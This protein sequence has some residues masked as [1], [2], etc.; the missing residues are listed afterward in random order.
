MRIDWESRTIAL[1]VGDLVHGGEFRRGGLE[2]GD[3]FRRM[4]LGQE[5]H[6]RR[7]EE[8]A[9]AD[10]NYR[11]E[12][13]VTHTAEIKDWKLIVSGRIDGLSV[14]RSTRR[15]LIEEVKSIHF[16]MELAALYRSEKL[17]R[18]LFQLML[19]AWFLSQQEKYAGHEFLPRWWNKTW[20]TKWFI[21]TTFHDQHHKYFNYN[22]GGYTQIWDYLCGTVRKKYE[23]DFENPKGRQAKVAQPVQA[24]AAMLAQ[25]EPELAAS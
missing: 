7:A 10:P 1:S 25:P 5:I 11:P 14:D 9:N 24:P 22:F 21:T 12:V 18:H 3:G 23:A 19:Y 20:A 17:H 4:W 8:Q 6:S 15:V 16:E 13:W 2:R